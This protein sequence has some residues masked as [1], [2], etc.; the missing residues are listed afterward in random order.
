MTH[1]RRALFFPRAPAQRQPFLRLTRRCAHTGSNLFSTPRLDKQSVETDSSPTVACTRFDITRNTGADH[2]D[3][4]IE[5]H[6]RATT[7][8]RHA[9][10]CVTTSGGG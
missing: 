9:V 5:T 2:P 8:T 6:Q 7:G 1:I 4:E 3:T 10:I